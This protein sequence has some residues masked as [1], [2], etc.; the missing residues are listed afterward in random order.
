LEL[1]TN[2]HGRFVPESHV[3]PGQAKHL[4]L[5]E[6]ER[7]GNRPTGSTA[8]ATTGLKDGGHL[9]E[10]VGLDLAVVVTRGVGGLHRVAGDQPSANG[11]VEGGTERPAT[12]GGAKTALEEVGPEVLDVRRP[13]AVEADLADGSDDVP[14]VGPV[15]GQG[16]RPDDAQPLLAGNPF[17]DELPRGGPARRRHCPCISGPLQLLDLR[18][19]HRLGLAGD[20]A[21]VLG[22]VW[23]DAHRHPPMPTP[24]VALVDR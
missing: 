6:A 5:T 23:S 9:L 3:I 10:G 22:P 8:G 2:G 12:V 14:F 19:H 20:V 4:A 7:Q 1:P 15:A 16:Q 21:A 13:E 18:G 24:V 17:V 11:V